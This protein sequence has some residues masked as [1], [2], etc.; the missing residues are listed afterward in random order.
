[1]VSF[2]DA[3]A[4]MARHPM[5]S[6]WPLETLSTVTFAPHAGIGRGTTVVLSWLPINAS[7]LERQVFGSAHASM[8][9]GWGGTM[10]QLKA[11]L[12]AAAA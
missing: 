7:E 4:G 10:D 11:Y 6:D 1:M 12:S 2:S 8:E 3:Q 5:S 9:Q